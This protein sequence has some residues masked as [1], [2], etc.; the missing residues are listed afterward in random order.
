MSTARQM[1]TGEGRAGG[2]G[3]LWDLWWM[4]RRGSATVAAR[5]R[6]RLTDL[7]AYARA[8]SP[9]YAA[10]YRGLPDDADLAALPPLTKR[11]LMARFDEWVTDPQVRLADL[12]AFLADPHRVGALYRGRY[13]VMT[14]SGTTGEPA[15]LV[16]DRPA[17]AVYTA[18]GL[19]R[20]FLP[21]LDGRVI[22]RALR[23]GGRAAVIVATGGHYG[24]VAMAE[25]ARRQRPGLAR[26]FQVLSVLTPLPDLVRTLNAFQPAFLGGYATVLSLLAEEQR[27]GRLTL[28]PAMVATVSETLPPAARTAMALAF[29]CPVLDI[30][31]A[32]EMLTIA[33]LCRAG[34]LHLNADW[35]VLEPVTADYRPVPPGT[36]SRTVLLTNLAN[37]VQ[38]ILRY[39]LGDSVTLRPDPC[40]CGSP[41]PALR[42]EGRTDEILTFRGAG[43][44]PVRIAPMAL[45]T[46]VEETPG[47]RRYQ[48]LQTGPQ[49]LRIRLAVEPGADPETVWSAVAARLRAF[50]AVQGVEGVT[51]ERASEP[52]GPDPRS[53]KFRFVWAE[54][55]ERPSA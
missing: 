23:Q 49:A 50:L 41:L 22:G 55:R 18:L 40:P 42:V 3:L 14:T 51:I 54:R 30:Y 15:V 48:I 44:Q 29:G 31:G 28:A 5:Q 4:A 39:D 43:G 46:V 34:W 21:W 52:P 45:A 13:L 2:L 17:L 27:A 37:R 26:R 1:P 19:L 7:V 20:G 38:P 8:H 16:H 9:L 47:V 24:A 25:W 53:G 33:F 10:L 36:P 35:V 11:D 32:S 12:R 6:A